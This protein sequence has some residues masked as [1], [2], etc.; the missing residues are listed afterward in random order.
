MSAEPSKQQADLVTQIQ[1]HFNNLCYIMY[2][3]VGALQ[4]RHLQGVVYFQCLRSQQ[5]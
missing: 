3:H 1:D 4:V 5:I 2:N